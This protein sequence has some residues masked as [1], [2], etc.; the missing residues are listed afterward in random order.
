MGVACGAQADE[1]AIRPAA[2]MQ[3]HLEHGVASLAIVLATLHLD[4]LAQGRRS[5]H[6]M[7]NHK[8]QMFLFGL[9]ASL[10]LPPWGTLP[11]NL[12]KAWCRSG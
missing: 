4:A 6:V 11:L 8:L 10:L 7:D 12:P 3:D 5:Y 1:H 9:P 2:A